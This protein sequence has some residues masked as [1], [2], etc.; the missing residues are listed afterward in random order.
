MATCYRHPDRETGVSCSN[1]GRPICPD[2]MTP[3]PVG[4]RCPECSRER[5]PVRNDGVAATAHPVLTY[6][7]IA[8]QRRDVRSARAGHVGRR[9]ASTSCVGGRAAV[10]NGRYLARLSPAASCTP[11]VRLPAHPAS[12]CTCCTSSA[13]CS[14]RH[15]QA[16]LRRA[17]LHL[18]A[19]RLVRRDPA[20][21]PQQLHGRRIGRRVRP[22]GRRRRLPARPRHQPDAIRARP[23]DPPQPAVPV[24]VPGANISIGGHIFGLA[25]GLA[26]GWIITRAA[27]RRMGPGCRSSP[28][29]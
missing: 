21:E 12:T 6:V 27:E 1:C 14:S 17:L 4:M 26:T 13:S 18:A 9:L 3:T 23:D 25:G 19:G 2:C 11:R 28:A 16:A 7:L 10:A 22:D 15:R 5:T 24:P 29:S 20:L 8:D